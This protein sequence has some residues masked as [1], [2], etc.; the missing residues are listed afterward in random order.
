MDADHRQIEVLNH[1]SV[2]DTWLLTRSWGVYV[3]INYQFII[4]GAEPPPVGHRD[5]A[6]TNQ[7]GSRVLERSLGDCEA[8]VR[9]P[10]EPTKDFKLVVE[11]PSSNTRHI[12]G[13][14]TQK[15]VDPLPE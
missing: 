9:S 14:S 8:R 4:R 3:K 2:V 11:A 6:S 10:A 5:C 15:L 7:L 13:S 1:L 12:K